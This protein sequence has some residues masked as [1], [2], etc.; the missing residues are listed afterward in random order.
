MAHAWESVVST[1]H[2]GD[3]RMSHITSYPY[4]RVILTLDLTPRVVQY[5]VRPDSR[6]VL[7]RRLRTMT[8]F[9]GKC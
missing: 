2:S 8:T 7:E 3:W 9:C 5:P 6:E 4:P 1:T